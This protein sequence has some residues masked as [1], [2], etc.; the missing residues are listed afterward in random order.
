MPR[1]RRDARPLLS[2]LQIRRSP[3]AAP[4]AVAIWEMPIR[5]EPDL[6]AGNTHPRGA[7]LNLHS[8]HGGPAANPAGGNI[9]GAG[10]AD[11]VT[12]TDGCH[13][14]VQ[15]TRQVLRG[16]EAVTEHDT[17]TIERMGGPRNSAAGGRFDELA[18]ERAGLM[19]QQVNVPRARPTMKPK[20]A[21]L[22]YAARRLC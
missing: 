10:A 12:T 22:T 11:V 5:V 15:Q 17:N 8:A 9:R 4:R 19:E 6:F 7:G 2:Q 3:Y 14:C 21:R 16:A 1:R 18:P 13:L 20:L